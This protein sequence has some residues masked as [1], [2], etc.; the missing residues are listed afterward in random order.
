[1]FGPVSYCCCLNAVW[2]VSGELSAAKHVNC[3]RHINHSKT[4]GSQR[5]CVDK[6]SH[7][8]GGIYHLSS[9]Q[10]RHLPKILEQQALCRR[11]LLKVLCGCLQWTGIACTG[12]EV[13]LRYCRT[14][15]PVV[16]GHPEDRMATQGLTSPDKLTTRTEGLCPGVTP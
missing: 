14:D 11:T 13:N 4:F 9:H 1:M 2:Q 3:N 10:L 7:N 6:H 16:A 12:T 15:I 5:S 8:R